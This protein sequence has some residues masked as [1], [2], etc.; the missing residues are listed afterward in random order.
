MTFCSRSFF[1]YRNFMPQTSWSWQRFPEPSWL[2]E[3]RKSI[4]EVLPD[5][6]SIG[7]LHQGLLPSWGGYI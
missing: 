1:G 2:K 7:C 6:F 4:L 3:K 5:T